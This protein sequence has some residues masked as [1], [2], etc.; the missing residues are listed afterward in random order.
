M[1]DMVNAKICSFDLN[2]FISIPLDDV[3]IVRYIYSVT[4]IL[5]RK[6]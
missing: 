3:V 6:L 2:I 5:L 1:K 4:G